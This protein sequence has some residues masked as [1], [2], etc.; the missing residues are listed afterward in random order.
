MLY[1]IVGAMNSITTVAHILRANS[2][3]HLQDYARN[4]MRIESGGNANARSRT[5]SATG[6]FQ[7]VEPTW[8]AVM[9]GVPFSEA[10][11][12]R[13]NTIAFIKLTERNVTHLER[14]LGRPPQDWEVYLAHFAGAGR[15]VTLLRADENTALSSIFDSNAMARNPHL[16]RLGSVG[17]YLEWVQATYAGEPYRGGRYANAGS[18]ISNHEDRFGDNSLG[19]QMTKTSLSHGNDV[20]SALDSMMALLSGFMASIAVCISHISD[21]VGEGL[22]RLGGIAAPKTP[23]HT[24]QPSTIEA[25]I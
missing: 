22:A 10:T 14:A 9:P 23:L 24:Q 12:P 19:R 15:A 11:D 21:A 4:T 8:K 2:V 16:G 1:D 7:F 20:E 17:H 25:T 3:E 18:G 5:S 6:L 13:Q